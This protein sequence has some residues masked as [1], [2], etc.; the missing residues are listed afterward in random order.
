MPSSP[1][2]LRGAALLGSFALLGCDQSVAALLDEGGLHHDASVRDSAGESSPTDATGSDASTDATLDVRPDV[3]AVVDAGAPD[4]SESVCS[5]GT[6][7]QALDLR[8]AGLYSDWASKT[9]APDMHP[10]AP[11]VV[12]WSDSALKSRWVYLPPGQTIDTSNMNEWTFPV[13][14]KFFK[15]F[16]IPVGDASTPIRIETRLLWKQGA[17][18]WYKTTYRWSDDGE[19]SAQEL[20][21]G[22]LNANGNGYEVPTQLECN[23]CHQGRV[24]KILGFEALALSLPSATG[25]TMGALADGGLLTHLPDASLSIPGDAVESAA[26]GWMHMNCGVACHNQGSGLAHG[27]GF[28]MRLDVAELGS[29]AATDTYTSGWNKLATGFTIPDASATYLLHACDLAESAAYYRDSHRDDMTPG[30]SVQMPPIDSH[31]VDDAGLSA[32]AAWIMEG[33]P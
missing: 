5:L 10:F 7:G 24:D 19:T 22:Q 32:V 20:T 27:T 31:I 11:G 15:E 12:L 23:T 8:C 3:A 26:L 9:V 16:R 6:F 18:N 21:T 2:L 13:G 14:T 30:T 25:F 28:Y 1:Q 17:G 29:V 4:A 33:C